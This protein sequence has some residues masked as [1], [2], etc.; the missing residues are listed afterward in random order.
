[1]LTGRVEV[2][3]AVPKLIGTEIQK[4]TILSGLP[5]FRENLKLVQ[6]SCGQLLDL[7]GSKT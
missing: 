3:S 6:D 4:K 5:K 1:M 2:A 7:Y